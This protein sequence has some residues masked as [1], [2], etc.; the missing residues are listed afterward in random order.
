M[1]SWPSPPPYSLV[2]K[3]GLSPV[4]NHDDSARLNFL[5]QLKTHLANNVVPA[6]ARA[7]ELRVKPEFEKEHGRAP[8][9]RHE[10]RRAMLKNSLFQ[11]WSALR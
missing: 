10:V 4:T 3:H 11:T 9:D 8:T 5:A 7:Y 2:G 1:S 6:N